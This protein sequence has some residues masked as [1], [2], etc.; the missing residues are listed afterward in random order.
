M[1]GVACVG[2]RKGFRV[3]IGEGGELAAEEGTYGFVVLHI[4]AADF[5]RAVV[6][7]EVGGELFIFAFA[8]EL[9]FGR[10]VGAGGLSQFLLAGFVFGRSDRGRGRRG[11]GRRGGRV[12]L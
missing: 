7:V 8:D 5:A 9:A 3:E 2:Q 4:D 10:R 12:G 11:R 1:V 6:E